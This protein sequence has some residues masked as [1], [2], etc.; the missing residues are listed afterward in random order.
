L[1]HTADAIN[2]R[3]FSSRSCSG[4]SM[5][6]STVLNKRFGSLLQNLLRQDMRSRSLPAEDQE[7]VSGCDFLI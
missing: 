5:P 1:S 7:F 3:I 6:S 4:I 2:G